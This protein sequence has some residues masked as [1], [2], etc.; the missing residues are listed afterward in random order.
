MS[1]GEPT[2]LIGA[3]AFCPPA[4]SLRSLQLS[5]PP[6]PCF[7]PCIL[8]CFLA[9][10]SF[11]ASLPLLPSLLHRPCYARK[12][13]YTLLLASPPP[14]A[15]SCGPKCPISSFK[16]FQ[17]CL[18]SH[19]SCYACRAVLCCAGTWERRQ[20]AG[21]PA[22]PVMVH[23]AGVNGNREKVGGRGLGLVITLRSKE[24]NVHEANRTPGTVMRAVP[25]R[26]GR[27]SLWC[28]EVCK[29]GW[30]RAH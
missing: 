27:C 18:A 11:P 30:L 21:L 13:F 24:L 26:S 23:A 10:A 15:P 5:L 12:S 14:S 6:W 2:G 22:K 17:Q 9:P 16:C 8:P 20:E 3:P 7:L 19:A 25:Q 29:E 28:W 1:N 4:S